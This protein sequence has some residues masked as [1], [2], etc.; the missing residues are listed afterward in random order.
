MWCKLLTAMDA[1][2]SWEK[3]V[4][5]HWT[6]LQGCAQQAQAFI[7]IDRARSSSRL[8]LPSTALSRDTHFK[9]LIITLINLLSNKDL[10]TLMG[11]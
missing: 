2:A 1:I 3:K 4:K 7:R 10:Q 5:D 11:S 6:C 8:L 9:K